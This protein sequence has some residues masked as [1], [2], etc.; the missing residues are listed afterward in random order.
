M[1]EIRGL[2]KAW[3]SCCR[4]KCHNVRKDGC[5][6]ARNHL[7]EGEVDTTLKR[8]RS[9]R[10]TQ[11][12]T[13]LVRILSSKEAVGLVGT[14]GGVYLVPRIK[15]SD[16]ETKNANTV[17]LMTTIV[18]LIGLGQA[19]VGDNTCL[20]IAT[21]AGLS[22]LFSGLSTGEKSAIVGVGAGIGLTAFLQGLLAAL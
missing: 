6:D 16:D 17:A 11:V 13:E 18:V 1:L 8:E 5:A 22:T 20:A 4:G 2:L 12:Q 9:K 3:G 10:K 7:C 14:L 21:A 19:G 15:W